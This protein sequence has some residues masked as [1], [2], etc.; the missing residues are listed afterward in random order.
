MR[1]QRDTGQPAGQSLQT[2]TVLTVLRV[3]LHV[4]F[5]FLLLFGAVATWLAP[6]SFAKQGAVLAL[7]LLLGGSYLWGTVYENRRGLPVSL[8]QVFPRPGAPA[9]YLPEPAGASLPVAL[10]L[11]CITLLWLGLMCLSS[12][13]TWVVFPLM[14]LYLH[15]LRPAAGVLATLLLCAL[16]VALPLV[17]P[18]GF[19]LTLLREA[20]LAPGYIIGPTLGALLAT[21]ISFT[22]RTLR[23]DAAC[24]YRLAERLRAVQAQLI[25]QQYSAGKLEERERLAR[26][27]HDTLAQGLSS[28][29]LVSRAAE[30]SLREQDTER[31]ARQLGVISE[32]AAE[33]LAEARRFVRDLASPA[34]DDS[35][36][37]ALSQLAASTEEAQRASGQESGFTCTFTFEGSKHA[38][39]QLAEPVSAALMRCAQG[40]LANVVAHSGASVC[41][42]TLTLWAERIT[43]DVVDN[44][45][46]FVP[47]RYDTSYLAPSQEGHTGFGLTAMADRVAALGGSLEIDGGGTGTALS[48]SIPLTDKEL[49]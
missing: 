8:R 32:S 27:I 44:G 18:A 20:G 47:G 23:E 22:Y 39:R 10:W 16:A 37:S 28:I 25:Q 24:Q 17:G 35:L 14:F 48:V 13:F 11:T 36:V 45:S 41:A 21:V 29:V 19:G 46:G 3:S 7:S 1:S 30:R 15:L 12:S 9:T 34:L 31:A 4:M 2:V 40:A 49:S 26:E 6:V 33:N 38:A 43:L 42:L 5:A